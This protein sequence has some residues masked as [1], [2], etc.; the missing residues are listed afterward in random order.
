MRATAA[1]A[2][3]LQLSS[4]LSLDAQSV[5]MSC[6]LPVLEK[7]KAAI[8]SEPEHLKIKSVRPPQEIRQIY[9][10]EIERF[11]EENHPQRQQ[12][13]LVL[14]QN[15]G[16]FPRQ[17]NL[18]IRHT[19]ATLGLGE[20]AQI[21]QQHNV[22]AVYQNSEIRGVLSLGLPEKFM[23]KNFSGTSQRKPPISATSEAICHYY[24]TLN[25]KYANIVTIN[26]QKVRLEWFGLAA[27]GKIIA[28]FFTKI[29]FHQ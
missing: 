19:N 13:G 24:E 8:K 9:P 1:A 10:N 7:I 22:N 27:A 17:I 4:Q 29:K 20:V 23:P 25:P 3:L 16:V 14:R 28:D 6:Y 12:N 18:E 5:N 21:R 15:Y 26:R 11:P 2:L